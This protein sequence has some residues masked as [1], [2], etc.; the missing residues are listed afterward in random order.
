[1]FL[2]PPA[3]TQLVPLRTVP[4][5][6]GD[7]GVFLPSEALGMGG[8]RLALDDTLGD[9]WIHPARG[10]RL[11]G[12]TLLASPTLY[13]ISADGGGGRTFPLTAL[14][15]GERWFGGGTVALQQIDNE[16]GR[17]DL[18][19]IDPLPGW[20][21]G[22]E[23]L[24]DRSLRNLYARAFLGR[25]LGDG[26]WS[27]GVGV[28]I[29][30][31]DAVDGV[32]L[33]YAGA[34]RIEQDGTTGDLRFGL[35]RDGSRDRLALQL[36]HHR[37]DVVHEVTFLDLFWPPVPPEGEWGGPVVERR[38]EINEDRT[39]TWGVHVA[40]DRTLETAGWTVGASATANRKSHPGI[41]DYDIQNI[42]RDPGTTWAWEGGVGV[43]RTLERTTVGLDLVLQP[44]WS[45]TWQEADA[46][47][48]G[49]DGRVLSPGDRTIEN[50]FFFTNVMVR[51]GL[52]HRWERLTAQAGLELRSYDYELEQVNHLTGV[53][54][55][56]EEGWMEW[57][58]SVGA[59]W[60]LGELELRYVGRVTTGT[61]RPGVAFTGGAAVA[62]DFADFIVAPSG[63][64]TLQDARVTTH[65][66]TVRV[67]VR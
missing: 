61:G 43:A 55:R 32:D 49:A 5:A 30:E 39:R 56:Q 37:V 50:D 59:A 38:I 36:L 6:S 4:V 44:I 34:E 48:T 14:L 17:G 7:Q 42:P 33:L 8:V 66:V 35:F 12:A 13:G 51:A 53:D 60:R 9:A 31:L 21:G 58:P 2:P 65:Q 11:Q 52:S 27:V 47:L 46:T 16:A 41:P 15:A 25:R 62:E 18:V 26:P 67:P 10:A 1:L 29:A 19:V 24:S 45:D 28:S 63:P 3:A 20:G 64:L 22:E 23:R 54:R 40:W 57:T